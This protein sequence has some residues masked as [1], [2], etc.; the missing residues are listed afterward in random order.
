MHLTID[1]HRE[2]SP[3]RINSQVSG[4]ERIKILRLIEPANQC[5]KHET[6]QAESSR[7]V[8]EVEAQLPFIQLR[9]S[10]QSQQV[11]Q[12]RIVSHKNEWRNTWKDAHRRIQHDVD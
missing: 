1:S 6:E 5:A 12:I 2:L 9:S 7:S 4:R 11:N 10:A 3:K 8:G